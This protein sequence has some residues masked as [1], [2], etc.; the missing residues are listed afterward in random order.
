M[1]E[2]EREK[3][4]EIQLQNRFFG[5]VGFPRITGPIKLISYLE[6]DAATPRSLLYTCLSVYV[7]VFIFR[8][9]IIIS[10]LYM[11]PPLFF[12]PIP[13]SYRV[14]IEYRSIEIFFTAFII[15]TIFTRQFFSLHKNDFH[16]LFVCVCVCRCVKSNFRLIDFFVSLN[17]KV[18]TITQ[19][20]NRS[21]IELGWL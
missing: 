18:K 14:F 4:K 5:V 6:I 7:N 19:K 2:R 21:Q 11:N 13:L 9:F 3:A 20:R 8:D 17:I 10:S 16:L 15:F 12:H 1:G